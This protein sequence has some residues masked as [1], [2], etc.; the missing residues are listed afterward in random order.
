MQGNRKTLA[1]SASHG[2]NG[3]G[4][5]GIARILGSGI[6]G[7]SE[8]IIFHPVD[9]IAKRLMSNETRVVKGTTTETLSALN[10]I[11]FRKNANA[12]AVKKF[13]SLFPGLGFGAGYKILQ[14][15]E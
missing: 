10:S 7:V 4:G 8:L 12:G 14:R 6:A 11:I 13:V 1:L 9:T 15:G 3:G 5:S 2:E